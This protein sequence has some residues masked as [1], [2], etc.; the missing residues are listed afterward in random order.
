MAPSSRAPL[1]PSVVGGCGLGVGGDMGRS[2]VGEGIGWWW[3]WSLKKDTN[4]TIIYFE[5]M[6]SYR[7]RALQEAIEVKHSKQILLERE[8][9]GDAAGSCRS[10]ALEEA[11]EVRAPEESV[12]G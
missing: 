7:S 3:C 6:E 12:E 10:R 2:E 8:L 9:R 1:E 4:T 11:I 5:L